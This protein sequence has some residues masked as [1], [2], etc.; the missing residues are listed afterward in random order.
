MANLAELEKR[1]LAIE[2]VEAIKRLKYRYFRHL[3]RKEWQELG[4]CF[5]P[6][7]T[8]AYGGGRYRYQGRQAILGFLREALGKHTGSVTA[9][10]GHHPEIELTDEGSARGA[11][12]L[13][14]Y[15][16]NEPERR[17]IRIAAYYDDEYVKRDGL[18][19]I[20]HTGYTEIFHEEW[21]R[22]DVPS[23]RVL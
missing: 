10:H 4:D 16:F 3:D 19:R 7:A 12:A 13:Y 17:G 21:S 22:D 6:E 8:V 18:W 9:H 14:N 23:L 5:A 11:W 20:L 1:I 15:M 2:D